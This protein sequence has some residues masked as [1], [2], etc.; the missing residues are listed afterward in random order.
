MRPATGQV[1]VQRRRAAIRL[2]TVVAALAAVFAGVVLWRSA[3][4]GDRASGGPPA[5][6]RTPNSSPST[7]EP[8][9]TT[10]ELCR[11][12]SPGG[13]TAPPPGKVTVTAAYP[14]DAPLSRTTDISWVSYA[15][16]GSRL[17]TAASGT[18]TVTVWQA[19]TGR[20]ITEL[21]GGRPGGGL[22]SPDGTH[23]AA[24]LGSAGKPTDSATADPL[25]VWD[26]R[27]GGAPVWQVAPA[28]LREMW[29]FAVAPDGAR[30]ATAH[31]DGSVRLWEPPG[32]TPVARLQGIAG[33]TRVAFTPDGDRLVS[34]HDGEEPG[35]PTSDEDDGPGQP[36]QREGHV[37]RLWDTA[38]HKQTAELQG[39]LDEVTHLALSPDGS[40]LATAGPEGTVRLWDTR[41]GSALTHLRPEN[42]QAVSVVGGLQFSRDGTTLMSTQMDGTG[43]LWDVASGSELRCFN[44]VPAQSVPVFCP[45]DTLVLTVGPEG[46][47]YLWSTASGERHEVVHEVGPYADGP[48]P[49]SQSPDCGALTVGTPGWAPEEPG[50]G[51]SINTYTLTFTD[52]AASGG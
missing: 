46:H 35:E 6:D 14:E 37:I 47:A 18:G 28:Q 32:R 23:L 3:G 29:D 39:H 48:V 5:A 21:T 44:G 38:T 1:A 49:S 31:A 50:A 33:V 4:E 22:L 17:L 11:T 25:A 7:P 15:L 30:V 10:G 51:S 26:V 13:P 43:R 2:A 52:T 20:R 16:D 8:E 27:R 24:H 9:E 41:K 40:T 36:E 19:D 42:P 34:V 12:R 45:G